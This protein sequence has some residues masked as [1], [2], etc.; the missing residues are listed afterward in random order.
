[1]LEIVN[2]AIGGCPSVA[3][4]LAFLLSCAVLTRMCTCTDLD[5]EH[6]EAIVFGNFRSFHALF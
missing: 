6:A 3:P 2:L 5:V 4:V 1:M